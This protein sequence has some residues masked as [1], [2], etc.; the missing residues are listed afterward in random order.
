MESNRLTSAGLSVALG[1]LGLAAPMQ[2]SELNAQRNEQQARVETPT[3]AVVVLSATEGN[4][5]DGVLTLT[6]RGES[7]RI[8]GR[9]SGLEPGKH[10]FHIHEYGDL[11]DPQGKSA[12][13]HF[14]PTDARHG[15][16]DDEQRHAGDLGNIE[17]NEDGIA[18][19]DMTSEGLQLH[20]V[21]GRALVVH[22]G[23]DDFESQPSGDA[24]ARVALGVI[25][26]AEVESEGP[27]PGSGD[28]R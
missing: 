19:V 16:P 14:N 12:G 24:G 26:I 25:G 13:G 3:D 7:V 11:R 8:R 20:F 2:L 5:V 22:G 9:V 6:A 4:D 1:L 21:I 18:N 28:A 23:E 10:G 15:A 17:A 27:S